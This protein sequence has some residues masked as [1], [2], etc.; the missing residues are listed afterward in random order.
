MVLAS[1]LGFCKNCMNLSVA[2]AMQ[3]SGMATAMGLWN[4][5]VFVALQLR[6][7]PIAQ[8][9]NHVFG[10]KCDEMTTFSLNLFF[11]NA[12]SHDKTIA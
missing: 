7:C 10:L 5:V 2:N 12:P 1:K 9:A 3:N 8:R 11:L 4:E 6:N